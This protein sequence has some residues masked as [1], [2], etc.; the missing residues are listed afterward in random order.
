MKNQMGQKEASHPSLFCTVVPRVGE[1]Q[2]GDGDGG[3]ME[4]QVRM[5]GYEFCSISTVSSSG[6]SR[7]RSW[8][9]R[10][11]AEKK[12]NTSYVAAA[13]HKGIPHQGISF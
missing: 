5:F 10:K 12:T 1:H 3:T 4:Q 13:L 6:L 9:I 2:G 7:T 11:G 8:Q